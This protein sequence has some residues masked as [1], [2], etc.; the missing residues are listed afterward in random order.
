M[1]CGRTAYETIT[2]VEPEKAL[3]NIVPVDEKFVTYN[4]ENLYYLISP[5]GA[6]NE[7]NLDLIPEVYN[8]VKNG[9]YKLLY[10]FSF[11][12]DCRAIGNFVR[13]MMQHGIENGQYKILISS[14]KLE[15]SFPN[16]VCHFP[17]FEIKAYYSVLN[18]HTYNFNI[19]GR[20]KFIMLNA[21]PRAHRLYL[22]Y[23]LNMRGVINDGF[24]SFPSE[25]SYRDEFDFEEVFSKV[26][27]FDFDIDNNWKADLKRKLPLEVDKVNYSDS[28]SINDTIFYDI[29]NQIDFAVVTESLPDSGHGSV[30]IT[31]KTFKPI[32]NKKPFVILG[33]KHTLKYL[34]NLG[35]RTFDF[36]ID[37]TYDTLDYKERI[38]ALAD[39]IKRLCSINF[40]RYEK[41]IKEVTEHNYNVLMDAS[42]YTDRINRTIDFLNK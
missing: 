17:M 2:Y 36:L 14:D 31:E 12:G 15:G 38:V 40:Q 26:E 34:K 35:Y 6:H 37:E 23:L 9:K 30:F 29:Y 41:Q 8:D 5:N 33:D 4:E 24:C 10:D 21:R 16:F 22:T 18:N 11:E 27:Y 32:A 42:R 39:E 25:E 13:Q 28:F 20:K 3:K 1:K 19:P 7:D